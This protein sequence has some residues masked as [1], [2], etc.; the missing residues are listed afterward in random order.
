MK[1]LTAL[2]LVIYSS[3]LLANELSPTQWHASTWICSTEAAG[4][5]GFDKATK[6]WQGK[7]FNNKDNFTLKGVSPLTTEEKL[8]FGAYEIKDVGDEKG[9]YCFADDLK[10]SSYFKCISLGGM[11][12]TFNNHTKRFMAV[13]KGQYLESR[14]S[15][16]E[17]SPKEKKTHNELLPLVDGM[18]D[19]IAI[20]I[21]KC[22]KL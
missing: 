9:Q 10:T 6:R 14:S 12:F 4:G 22:S 18:T 2:A 11:E 21:G 5:L 17:L 8:K 20:A 16:S 7:G 3:T 13:Y 19:D 15:L 1:R